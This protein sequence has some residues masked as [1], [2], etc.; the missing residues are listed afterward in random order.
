MKP[1]RNARLY[2]YNITTSRYCIANR[3][4]GS[5]VRGK[6]EPVGQAEPGDGRNPG[7]REG[8]CCR[9]EEKRHT[10]NGPGVHD[11]GR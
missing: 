2:I 11:K 1:L 6:T 3:Q 5:Y 8:A 10:G 7:N 4:E 9:R